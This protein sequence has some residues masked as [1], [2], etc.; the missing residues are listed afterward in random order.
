MELPP[1]YRVR[2]GLTSDLGLLTQ[3]LVRTY[4]EIFPQQP[5]FSHL[6]ETARKYFSL[7]TPLWWVES[8]SQTKPVALLWM[9]NGIDQVTG[10]RYAHIFLLYVT[11]PHRRQ[12]IAT[13]LLH[14]AQTWAK[15]RGDRQIGLQV[16]LDNQPACNLYQG[17]GFQ[18]QSVM[19][20]KKI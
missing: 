8:L 13:Y 3:F 17:F 20:L 16:F 6:Q 14:L 18:S 10:E 12:G 11:P 4:T 5:D 2:F 15:A 7:Q 9:G 19:M 1:G